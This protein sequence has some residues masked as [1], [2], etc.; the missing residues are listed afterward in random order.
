MQCHGCRRPFQ[1]C[2]PFRRHRIDGRLRSW[3]RRQ[4]SALPIQQNLPSKPPQNRGPGVMLNDPD[5]PSGGIV[6]SHA[7]CCPRDPRSR[8]LRPSRR[9]PDPLGKEQKY[10]NRRPAEQF[11][12]KLVEEKLFP[13]PRKRL[14]DGRPA[15]TKNFANQRQPVG[16]Q[17]FA[18]GF[19]RILFPPPMGRRLAGA[20]ER[21]RRRQASR[22][23]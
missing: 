22:Y 14:A 23:H 10:F 11:S 9:L 2:S 19:C 4:T 5:Q 13:S 3:R 16:L 8:S 20:L 1:I 17:K 15:G 7:E 6:L 12:A 18:P 21:A